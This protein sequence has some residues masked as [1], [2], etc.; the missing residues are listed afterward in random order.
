[1]GYCFKVLAA[2]LAGSISVLNAFRSPGA[3]NFRRLI[4][5]GF[6]TSNSDVCTSRINE[7][8]IGGLDLSS[9]SNCHNMHLPYSTGSLILMS[10]PNNGSTS[11]AAQRRRQASWRNWPEILGAVEKHLPDS[12]EPSRPLAIDLGCGTGDLAEIMRRDLGWN[13]LCG[14]DGDPDMLCAARAS[15]PHIEFLAR[16][17]SR[18]ELSDLQGKKVDIIWSSFTVQYFM[19]DLPRI[20]RESWSQ[21]LSDNGLLLLFETNGLFRIHEPQAPDTLKAWTD[22]E[23]SWRTE[24]GYDTTAAERIERILVETDF[25]IL[26]VS[27]WEDAEFAF[28]GPASPAILEAWKGRLA[29]IKAPRQLMGD[30][31]FEQ[32]AKEFLACLQGEEHR[33]TSRL[34]F[35]IARRRNFTQ[36]PDT[37]SAR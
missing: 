31:L 29:R 10:Q 33:T 22:M 27:E 35:F 4:Y 7:R 16:D 28:Q 21:L 8:C 17:L 11:V 20:L 34:R 6:Q 9:N 36:A 26:E 14:I 18:L 13:V 12:D 3:Q 32:S 19:D 24:H 25:E 2:R 37:E 5:H 23:E 30:E 1:M 15:Y